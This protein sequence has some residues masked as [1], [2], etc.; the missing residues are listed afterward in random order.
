MSDQ[1][2]KFRRSSVPGKVPTTSS[3][4]FGEF[5]INTYDGLAFLKKSGSNGEE[6]I[7]IGSTSGS[8]TGIFSGSFYGTSSWTE[9][10]NWGNITGSI[11]DQ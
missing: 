2:L 8:F 9:N 10:I 3:L 4:N 1:Y 5:A 7:P 6:I 11:T